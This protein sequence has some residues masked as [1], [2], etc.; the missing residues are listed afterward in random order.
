[1]TLSMHYLTESTEEYKNSILE[2]YEADKKRKEEEADAAEKAKQ[3]S[4]KAYKDALRLYSAQWDE[5]KRLEDLRIAWEEYGKER[6]KAQNVEYDKGIKEFFDAEQA[7]IDKADRLQEAMAK[8]ME[9]EVAAEQKIMAEKAKIAEK[10]GEDAAKAEEEKWEDIVAKAE[11]GAQKLSEITRMMFDNGAVKRENEMRAIDA[12]EEER[13][14][15]AGDNEEAIAAIEKEAE[16]RRNKVR[17]DQAKADKKEALFQIA[18]QTALAVVKAIAASPVTLGLPWSALVLAAG[19]AQAAI[20]NA[21]PLP[22]FAKGTNYSPEGHAV[23]GERGRELI[24]DGKT[25]QTRLSSETASIT[26][27]SRGS[28]V[29]P[30]HLTEK[31]LSD[32]NFDHNG[33]AEKYLNKASNIKV[34]K[35]A[36]DYNRIE[37]AFHNSVTQIPL[38]KTVFDQNGVTN[39]VVKR[40]STIRR[41]N[42]KY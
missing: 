17:I 10:A 11:F 18:I 20:V 1:M 35:P 30:H 34:E 4:D 37:Q 38:N 40:S 29:I 28:K 3:A 6:A 19:L 22:A 16:E 12:W 39:Y 13:I 24:V 8:E 9:A 33:V 7:K 27:L 5:H 36:V 26:H 32:P 21:R 14:G 23:V 25:G 42:K 2:L 31:L 41:I 15:M